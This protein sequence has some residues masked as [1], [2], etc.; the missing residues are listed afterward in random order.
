MNAKPFVVTRV[1]IR[2][3]RLP[4]GVFTIVV[5]QTKWPDFTRSA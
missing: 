2:A 4:P 1:C 3:R 5:L